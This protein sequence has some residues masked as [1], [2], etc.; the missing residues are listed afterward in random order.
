MSDDVIDLAGAGSQPLEVAKGRLTRLRLKRPVEDAAPKLVHVLEL[1]GVHFNTDSAVLLPE[2]SQDASA[3]K[4]EGEAPEVTGILAVRTALRFAEQYPAKRLLIAGHT[5]TTG[6][7][8]HNLDLSKKR[9]ENVA[10]FVRGDRAAWAASSAGRHRVADW[11]QILKWVAT[12]RGWDCDPGEVD[13][14]SGPASTGALRRFRETYRAEKGTTLPTKTAGPAIDDWKAFCALYDD[15]LAARLG[16]EPSALAE[17]RKALLAVDPPTVGCGEAWPVEKVGVD[18]YAS[19]ANRR[20]ELLFFD[21]LEAPKLACHQGATCTPA[22]CPLYA[23]GGA[24]K[25]E[26]IPVDVDD[27]VPVD[28]AIL[29]IGFPE[30][31]GPRLPDGLV[32]RL[33]A[34]ERP[35]IE[36]PWTDGQKRGAERVFTFEGLPDGVPFDLVAVVGQDELALW[37]QQ[38]LGG[39]APLVWAHVLD[40]LARAEA[41]PDAAITDRGPF[42]DDGGR[43]AGLRPIEGP[44]LA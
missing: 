42:P 4:T 12:T 28:G 16:C 8:A 9:A 22:A 6:G 25:A 24:Y 44:S 26:V 43:G 35:P 19:K 7:D 13:N 21:E 2:A 23:P 33:V 36:H 40:E 18:G 27:Y 3:A 20:V 10:A 14:K 1:Q 29:S 32:L 15:D 17:R 37:E 41:P 30:D 39:E 5:D 31:L 38:T 11:Q 34:G